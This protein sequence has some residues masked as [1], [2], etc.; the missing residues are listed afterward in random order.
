MQFDTAKLVLVFVGGPADGHIMVGEQALDMVLTEDTNNRLEFRP[1]HRIKQ[2]TPLNE[3]GAISQG[4]SRER[5]KEAARLAGIKPWGNPIYK[6]ELHADDFN[7]CIF[8]YDG[9]G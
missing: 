9:E 3:F 2:I 5:V 1:G 8:R 6:L 4:A 7:L